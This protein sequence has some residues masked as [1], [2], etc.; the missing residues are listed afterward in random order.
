LMERSPK[1]QPDSGYFERHRIIPGC[2]GGKYLPNNIAWLTPEEHYVAHQLL[3]KIHPSN[4]KLIYAALMLSVDRYGNR[5]NNKRYGWIKRRFKLHPPTR[6]K[7][8]KP[9]KFKT[10]TG[11]RILSKKHKRNIGLSIK[12]SQHSDITKQ[13]ISKAQKG[14]PRDYARKPSSKF[15]KFR[16]IKPCPGCGSMKIKP[17]SIYCSRICSNKNRQS[18]TQI[19][20]HKTI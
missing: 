16:K 19:W 2:M 8:T 11:K 9:R 6:A 5:V 7:E 1:I 20:N 17:G 4:S 15:S 18:N 10:K 13:R 12:G 3:V 14:K